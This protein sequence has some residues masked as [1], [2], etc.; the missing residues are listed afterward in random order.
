MKILKMSLLALA[1]FVL[2]A[3]ASGCSIPG[4]EGHGRYKT[5]LLSTLAAIENDISTKGEIQER[6]VNKL[7]SVLDKWEEDFGKKGSFIRAKE[8]LE[9]CEK[10]VAAAEGTDV[11]MTNQNIKLIN[12]G[13]RSYMQTEGDKS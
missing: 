12:D 2:G 7:R 8:S 11:F 9:L 6:N 3:Y 4:T 5:E 1:V 13:V 10:S